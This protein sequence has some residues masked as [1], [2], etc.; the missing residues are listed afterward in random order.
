MHQ[1][2][3]RD[4]L[5]TSSSKPHAK[6]KHGREARPCFAR[7]SWRHVRQR[8]MDM[9]QSKDIKWKDQ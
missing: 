7:K 1:D 8:G 3:S 4:D 6:H 9:T 5:P 2:A